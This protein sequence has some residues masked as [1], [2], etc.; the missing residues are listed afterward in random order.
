MSFTRTNS[1]ISNLRLFY[2]SDIIIY[3]EG[4]DKSFS[5]QD[6]ENNKFNTSSIDIKFWCGIFDKNNFSKKVKFRALGSKT[7]SKAICEK[8]IAGD[9]KNT[10]V[11]K[12]RDLDFIESIHYNSPLILYTKGYSWENDIFSEEITTAQIKSM[13]LEQ[14]LSTEISDEINS[15]YNQFRSLGMRLIRLEVIFRSHGK[16]FITDAN[17]ER[18]FNSKISSNISKSALVSFINNKKTEIPRPA[19]LN[20]DISALCPILN[21]YGKL[22]ASLSINI[23]NRICRNHSNHK[24]IPKQLIETSMIDRFINSQS[25]RQDIYYSNLLS[26]LEIELSKQ[27]AQP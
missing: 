10:V 8:I 13:L 18:F 22:L 6:V 17:G 24:S 27:T 15:S 3:T 11:T 4:G 20:K 25:L 2:N 5:I 12:D 9:I 23:I 1:G 21:I 14:E 19:N 7:A 26:N 16:K